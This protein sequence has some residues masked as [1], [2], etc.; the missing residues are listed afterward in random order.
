MK[1]LLLPLLA[2]LALPTAVNAKISDELHKKCLDARDYSGCVETNKKPLL[3]KDKN[4]GQRAQRYWSEL[5]RGIT[6]F[7][8]KRQK[9]DRIG[10]LNKL[11]MISYLNR[12][13]SLFD[14]DYL[15]IFSEGRFGEQG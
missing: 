13:R 15:F 1:R 12:I 2:V 5:D 8:A 10:S 7:D 6:S 11:D 3:Q 14:S 9:A 4:L